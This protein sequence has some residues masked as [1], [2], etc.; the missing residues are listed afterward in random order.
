MPRKVG[1]SKLPPVSLDQELDESND[2]SLPGPVPRGVDSQPGKSRLSV[3]VWGNNNPG[4]GIDAPNND[5]QHTTQIRGEYVKSRISSGQIQQLSAALAYDIF[6]ENRVAPGAL[7]TRWSPGKHRAEMG[8]LIVSLSNTVALGDGFFVKGGG[9]AGVVVTGDLG[10]LGLQDGWHGLTRMGER[11]GLPT[12]YTQGVRVAG[13]AG[14]EASVWKRQELGAGFSAEAGVG[15]GADVP[16]GATGIGNVRTHGQ[17]GLGSPGG[18]HFDVGVTGSLQWTKG[19]AFNFPKGGG[20][21]N[22]IVISPFAQ[23]AWSHAAFET[24]VKVEGNSYGTGSPMGT[25]T[26]TYHF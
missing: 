14:V 20:P 24:T 3:T 7:D 6:T 11:K 10:G 17:V 13:V 9:K 26:L 23:V 25:L 5:R 22:G 18:F 4:Q 21:V 8:S 19:Q 12:Q 2:G 1:S 15:T 16:L